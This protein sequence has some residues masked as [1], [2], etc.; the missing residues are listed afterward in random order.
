MLANVWQ[1]NSALSYALRK[2]N[3]SD[4]YFKSLGIT[5]LSRSQ[6]KMATPFH[7]HSTWALETYR[8]HDTKE[9]HRVENNAC[10]LV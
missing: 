2:D 3:F 1:E 5:E 10:P 8:M 4:S 6:A 9:T 7:I